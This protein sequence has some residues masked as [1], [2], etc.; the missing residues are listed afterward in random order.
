MSKKYA[1]KSGTTDNDFWISGYNKDALMLVWA[2]NDNNNKVSK[3]YSKIIKDIWLDTI[4]FYLKDKEDTWYDI[5]DN[6]VA[7]PMNPITGEYDMNSKTLYYF[8]KG[9]ELVYTK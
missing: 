5:P 6:V 2:G 9:T 3:N 1:L 4:E 8:I 7:V